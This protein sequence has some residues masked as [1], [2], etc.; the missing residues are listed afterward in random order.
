M[1]GAIA[2]TKVSNGAAISVVAIVV[3]AG[4]LTAL[5]EVV[6][7]LRADLPAAVIVAQ[8]SHETTLLPEILASHT[9]M[10]VSLAGNGALLRPG[11]VYVCPAAHHVVVNRNSTLRVSSGPR[12]RFFRPSGDWLFESASA[13]F[14]ARTVAIVLSGAQDDGARGT[15]AVRKAGGTVIAQDPGTCAYPEMPSAAISA[16]TVDHVLAADQIA[17]CVNTFM[18][19]L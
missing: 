9:T 1:E 14:G 8:H 5:R 2:N 13:S 10:P 18:S 6:G 15:V 11:H 4:G 17:H 16:G 12:V 3:S 19:R 7:G